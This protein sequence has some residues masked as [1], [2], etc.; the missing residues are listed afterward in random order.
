MKATLKKDIEADDIQAELMLMY[1][2][3]E[4]RKYHNPETGELD[5]NGLSRLWHRLWQIEGKPQFGGFLRGAGIVL[6]GKDNWVHGNVDI[7]I[8]TGTQDAELKSLKIML[9]VLSDNHI[10]ASYCPGELD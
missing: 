4:F 2:K 8:P 6:H 7:H 1:A 10:Q 9:R 5:H 3:D